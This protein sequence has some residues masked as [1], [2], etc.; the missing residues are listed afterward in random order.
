MNAARAVYRKIGNT[1]TY[2][3]QIINANGIIVLRHNHILALFRETILVKGVSLFTHF[4]SKVGLCR[5]NE[6]EHFF[7]APLVGALFLFRRYL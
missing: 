1:F 5:N 6:G 7:G 4:L 2:L 3:L